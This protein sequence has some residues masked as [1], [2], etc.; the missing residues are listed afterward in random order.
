MNSNEADGLCWNTRVSEAPTVAIVDDDLAVREALADLM[1]VIDLQCRTFEGGD[2]FFG[3]FAP[4]AFAC[5]ITDVKLIGPSGFEL[6]ARLRV[7]DPDLP[8]I[9]IT[10]FSDAATRARALHL[11]ALAF[12]TKP[13]NDEELHRWL[14][15]ALGQG[16][17]ST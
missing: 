4:G 9:V 5:V 10:S 3:A 7:L 1:E 8:V 16:R 12:L 14:T 13:V 11:G 6:Q 15:A 17:A 2:D